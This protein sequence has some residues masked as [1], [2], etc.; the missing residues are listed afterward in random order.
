MYPYI[1]ALSEQIGV[2]YVHI[3]NIRNSGTCTEYVLEEGY[4]GGG[5][6][7]TEYKCTLRSSHCT[8]GF[9]YKFV[10]LATL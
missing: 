4:R 8:K 5:A 10:I 7:E 1:T 2:L 9:Q 6:I 3:C